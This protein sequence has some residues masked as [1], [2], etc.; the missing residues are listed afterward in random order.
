[1]VTDR[2]GNP[3]PDP[4]LRDTENVPFTYDGNDRGAVG[5]DQVIK[6][7]VESELLPHVPD[8]WVDHTKTK[9]GYEIPFTR[10]FYKYVPPRPLYEIDAD[11]N[12][13][14]GEIL[15]LLNEVES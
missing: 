14:V 10:Q 6:S 2:R 15:V 13:I 5:S 4:K 8:A 3:K 7:Y 9:I 11:L 1:V 12:K